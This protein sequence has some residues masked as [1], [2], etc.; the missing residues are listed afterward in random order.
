MLIF[1]LAVIVLVL[2][3]TVFSRTLWMPSGMVERLSKKK[4]FQN[5]WLS[6]G[7][8][9]GINALYFGTTMLLL[10]LLMYTDIPY[11]HIVLMFLA[12]IVSIF[13]WSTVSTAWTG[14]FKNR[15]KMAL[16]G[17]SFY[18][19]LALIMVIQ[20][21]SVKP[22]YPNEDTFMRAL[23]WMLGFFVSAVAF[24][25]CFIFTAFLGKRSARV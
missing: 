9:F 18:L 17:S 10:Y 22:L 1:F 19:I 12:T 16:T 23:G 6:G 7:Y 25:I 8:L 5:H 14:P 3:M 11:L 15:L 13:T 20:W 24:S 4:W 2:V 21:L